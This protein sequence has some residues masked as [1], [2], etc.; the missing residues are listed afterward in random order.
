MS[1]EVAVCAYQSPQHDVGEQARTEIDDAGTAVE[2]DRRSLRDAQ[3]EFGPLELAVEE[4]T[5]SPA[6]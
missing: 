2:K 6:S 5:L 4:A 1:A 3:A